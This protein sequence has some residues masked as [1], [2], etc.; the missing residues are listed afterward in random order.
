LFGALQ[1]FNLTLHCMLL[2]NAKYMP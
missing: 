2:C 1:V